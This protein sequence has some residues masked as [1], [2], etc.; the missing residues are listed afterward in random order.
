MMGNL[1]LIPRSTIISLC[2]L[3]QDCYSLDLNFFQYKTCA[4]DIFLHFKHFF[5]WESY[6]QTKILPRN[7]EIKG[8]HL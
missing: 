1:N 5:N 2:D 6:F 3:K 7:N 4:W 8:K